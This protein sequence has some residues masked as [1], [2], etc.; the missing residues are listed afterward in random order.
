[1]RRYSFFIRLFLGNLLVISLIVG[2]GAWMAYELFQT[3]FARQ[4]LQQQQRVTEM[5][6]SWME[7]VW[8]TLL[9]DEGNPQRSRIDPLAKS[10]MAKGMSDTRVTIIAADGEVL[11][12]SNELAARK[13]INHLI[14]SR[15]EV[16]AAVAGRPGWDTRISATFGRM[17]RYH[18][19]PIFQQ[20]Q[21]AGVIRT[22][23][24]VE[25]LIEQREL[26]QRSFLLGLGA[27]G[28]AAIA[29][30]L[31][32]SWVWYT[33]LRKLTLAAR[34]VASGSL[35]K[36]TG[37][38]GHD[39]L[40]QLARAL[41]EMRENIAGQMELVNTQRANLQAVVATLGEGIIATNESDQVVLINRAACELLDVPADAPQ[42]GLHLQ[43]LVRVPDI[44]DL[45]RDV[46]EAGQ[47]SSIQ[48]DVDVLGRLRT[49]QVTAAPVSTGPA[50]GLRVLIVLYDVTDI[51]RAAVMKSEFVANASHELRTPLATIRA[52]VENLA[53]IEPSEPDRTMYEKMLDILNRH[54]DRLQN[55][56]DDLLNVH[57]VTNDDVS[58][59]AEPISLADLA[60]WAQ[61]QFGPRAE[62][63]GI[64]LVTEV[65]N[66]GA[67]FESDR[68]LV[69]MILQNLLDNAL[70]FTP[71]QGT[72]EFIG[73]LE[74]GQVH[75]AV[76]DTGCG[77]R[78]EDQSRIFERFYQADQARSGDTRIRGTGLGLA[79]V[80]HASEQLGGTIRLKSRLGVGTTIHVTLSDRI[81]PTRRQQR[82]TKR[83][84]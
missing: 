76:R 34:S 59:H 69:E 28:L 39:E 57:I 32:V 74:D 71:E 67:C 2:I 30:G 45:Y 35:Q 61:T 83:R 53:S 60:G 43:K 55:M 70:K 82:R 64:E 44:I 9:D 13:M 23:M 17:Y 31:L 10:R 80:K 22:A 21:V 68:K 72:V 47:A 24:R 36:R 58:L 73:R 7:H 79:I 37:L 16:V 38:G 40:G 62:E 78:P 77:I 66:D 6:Q 25:R 50:E 26:L 75:L 84:P 42:T 14:P 18:A 49:L 81:Q 33:P 1:M 29:L 11:G 41:D 65:D 19:L 3:R 4:D 63:R 54:V 15:P 46:Q 27:V 52:A 56:T 8:P 5:A 48:T 51:S 20:G 12:E